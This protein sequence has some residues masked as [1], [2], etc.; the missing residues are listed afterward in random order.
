MEHVIDVAARARWDLD[1]TTA[2]GAG[3]IL[4]MFQE[5]KNMML[6]EGRVTAIT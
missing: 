5:V 6:N 1:L 4:N 3:R 2:A